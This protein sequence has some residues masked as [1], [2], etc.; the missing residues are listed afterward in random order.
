VTA[1][2]DEDETAV[3]LD[4]ALDNGET[5]TTATRFRGEEGIEE[6]IADLDGNS[7]AGIANAQRDCPRV[8]GDADGKRV[9]GARGDIDV[10]D[11]AV[12][13][14]LHGVQHEIEHGPVE[15]IIVA[16]DDE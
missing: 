9:E 3:R 11:A 2:I 10:H 13:R 12:R 16:I 5:E 6:P 1:A 8:E 7:G 14:S 4:C 15:Q